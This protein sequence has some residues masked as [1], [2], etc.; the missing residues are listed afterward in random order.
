MLLYQYG[1]IFLSCFCMLY[2]ELISWPFRIHDTVPVTG[3]G[4]AEDESIKA[5]RMGYSAAIAK[6]QQEKTIRKWSTMWR[7]LVQSALDKTYL[8]YCAYIRYLNLADLLDMLSLPNFVG[9]S[10]V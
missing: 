6:R 7:S 5:R 4:S 1:L 2:Q 3:G 8:P 10:N 9:A